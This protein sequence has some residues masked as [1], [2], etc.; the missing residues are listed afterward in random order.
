LRL[1]E[2][3]FKSKNE[4]IKL[5]K[6]VDTI[7]FFME[8]KLISN[9]Y[10]METNINRSIY[11]FQIQE[12]TQWCT[13]LTDDQIQ[14]FEKDLGFIL[15][16][17]LRD[18]YK[19][20]NGLDKPGINVY[21]DCGEKF[22]YQPIYYSYPKDLG[23]I[24]EYIDWIYKENE[25]DSIQLREIGASR[26][27]P[28]CGHR[29]MLIDEATNPILSMFGNDIIYWTDSISKLLVNDIFSNIDN[30]WDFES[31]PADAPMIKFWINE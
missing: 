16:K 28:I 21:G 9:R 25:T 12:N 19:S 6:P 1:V 23:L 18:F 17:S 13:G 26:I 22:T 30:V 7:D 10:W 11:G 15:P 4:M 5:P 29:F 27:F 31:N 24:K 14:D 3:L 2:R 20:M 8:I